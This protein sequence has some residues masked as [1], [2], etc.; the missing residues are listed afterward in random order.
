VN[1]PET[2]EELKALRRCVN[3]GSPLGSETWTTR[4]VQKLGLLS[5]LRPRGRPDTF[6]FLI[7]VICPDVLVKGADYKASKVVGGKFVT[8]YGGRIALAPLVPGQSTTSILQK[9]ER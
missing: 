2:E 5:T 1:Q 4:T 6:S 8:S 7:E 3:R 9:L